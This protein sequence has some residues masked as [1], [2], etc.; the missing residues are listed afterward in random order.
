M[1]PFRKERSEVFSSRNNRQPRHSLL[2]PIAE[3]PRNSRPG[4]SRLIAMWGRGERAREG[5]D[6]FV[7]KLRRCIGDVGRRGAVMSSD[8]LDRA[9][10]KRPGGGE[11]LEL[12][13]LRSGKVRDLYEVDSDHLLMVAT[14]R[15]SAFDCI[16]PN[17]IPRKGEVLTQ[18]SVFWF[19]QL[20]A[21]VPN[22]LVTADLDHFPPSLLHR[23]SAESRRWLTGRAMLVRRA[24]VL[25][26]ECVVRGYLAGSGWKEYRETGAVCGH[27]LPAGLSEAAQLPAPIFTPATKAESGHDINV[28]VATMAAQLGTDLTHSLEQTSLALYRQ[29]AAY[30]TERG[31]IIADTKFEFGLRDGRIILIDEALTPDSSRFWPADR[32]RPGTSPP[33]FDKQFVRDYL[34]TLDWDKQPP[35]PPLPDDIVEATS[36]RYLEAYLLLT[37]KPLPSV[38]L[39][40]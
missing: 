26:F 7:A 18:L 30:A 29:A 35:A 12:P 23:L 13:F 1:R 16:L 9:D 20:A 5:R 36:A 34:E 28:S 14:D 11:D 22:H 37:G 19:H 10:G 33:S 31:I 38:A 25:P 32:Y 15:L 40:Q 2:E 21:L 17:A 8:Q 24:E 27:V 39:S 3:R 4:L 6:G